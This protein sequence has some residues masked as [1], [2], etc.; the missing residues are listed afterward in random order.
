[1]KVVIFFMLFIFSI[2]VIADSDVIRVLHPKV[3]KAQIGKDIQVKANII[4]VHRV[5]YILLHYKTSDSKNWSDIEMNP[6][7]GEFVAIIPGEEVTATGI[8]YYIE[9]VDV[10][11]KS[12]MAF[13]TADSPQTISA[14]AEQND[15]KNDVSEKKE[16]KKEEVW[17]DTFAIFIE[18]IEDKV[19]TASKYSQKSSQAAGNILVITKEEIREKGYIT[20]LE[21]LRDNGFD[22]NDNGS[23]SDIGF[24][25]INEATTYGKYLAVFI[26]SHAMNF[27]QFYRNIISS[28]ILSLRD[29]ERIEIQKGP[30]S[31]IWGANAIQAVINIITR[32]YE[33]TSM[34]E[35]FQG[36][37]EI[38]SQ[39]VRASK[40]FTPYISV[41]ASFF[42][43]SSDVSQDMKIKEWSEIGGKSYYVDN[44]SK[45]SYTFFSKLAFY[46]FKLTGYINHYDPYAPISTFSTGGDDTRLVTNHSFISLTYEKE[47]V[48]NKT[49]NFSFNT[50]IGYDLYEFG[51]GA[52]YE[53]NPYPTETIP[54]SLTKMKATDN[55]FDL[56]TYG[57][58]TIHPVHTDI[59]AGVDFDYLDSVRWYYPEYFK[60]NELPKPTFTQNNFGVFL[61][62]E[63][64]VF[65]MLKM[66]LGG[67]YDK[68]SLYDAQF[69]PKVALIFSLD[70]VYFKAI[71]GKGFKAPSLHDLYYFRKNSFYGNP[72]L[73]PETSTALEF[74]AGYS[75][76][77]FL[78]T[79]VTFFLMNIDDVIAYKEKTGTDDFKGSSEFPKEE[80]PS[81]STTT[82][83]QQENQGKYESMGGEI[84][85]RYYPVKGLYV[86]MKGGY[87]LP[88]DST[89]DERLNYTFKLFASASVNYL[90]LEKF[91]FNLSAIYTG[92]KKVPE[93]LNLL[94]GGPDEIP[95]T[96]P[97]DPTLE[98]DPYFL[99]NFNFYAKDIFMSGLQIGLIV[100]NILDV[101]YYDAGKTVLY[102]QAG[103]KILGYFRFRF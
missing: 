92:D 103:R 95:K 33:S 93:T 30:G 86:D 69:S 75:K 36:T 98:T 11:D 25:G 12:I 74:V 26:D 102:P 94:N 90:F 59:L 101:E 10:D 27:T 91:N 6:S 85:L 96:I 13:A 39:Y 55:R 4:N 53:A 42:S 29:I 56:K 40:I 62:G 28:G 57:V 63:T 35:V 5:N 51:Y 7:D 44:M 77:E 76:K 46:D 43:E 81:T 79:E 52:Q 72:E 20:V 54:S 1:M 80:L 78:T 65:D 49:L 64:T 45:K 34:I 60:D 67:R 82:Y 83:R 84:H 97:E 58:V 47:F 22:V 99:L 61:Q 9:I 71:I 50:T 37:H 31:S 24:R 21:I 19:V 88:K 8:S 73:I 87:Y 2:I 18:S 48:K 66:V 38:Q 70:N 68:N 23:W 15:V 17:D 14:N 16:E 100:D 41:F 89:E 32:K 3:T